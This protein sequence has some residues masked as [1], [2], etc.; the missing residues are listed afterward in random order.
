MEV[1]NTSKVVFITKVVL[2]FGLLIVA[3]FLFGWVSGWSLDKLAD[4]IL[5]VLKLDHYA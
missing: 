4:R 3:G 5:R 2:Y 1:L